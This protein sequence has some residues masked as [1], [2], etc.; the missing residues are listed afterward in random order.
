MAITHDANSEHD[1]GAITSTS[2]SHTNNG[3]CLIVGI[4]TFDTN[5]RTISTLTYNGVGMTLVGQ[6]SSDYI[7]VW[8]YRLVGPATGANSISIT[9]SGALSHFFLGGAISFNGVDQT[10]PI[11]D[12]RTASSNSTSLSVSLAGVTNDNWG[13]DVVGVQD[14]QPSPNGGQTLRLDRERGSD[15]WIA[16]STEV[17]D[18][19]PEVMSY[20]W[21]NSNLCA[22][23]GAELKV[24]AAAPT[25]PPVGGLS[26]VGVGR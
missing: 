17:I 5:A 22:M 18:S 9:F 11:G 24:A 16:M 12:I 10:T 20:S 7:R 21:S 26:L 3:N 15:N 1:A 23:V 6:N 8:M 25:G 19:D 4:S 2:W 14:D 13:V